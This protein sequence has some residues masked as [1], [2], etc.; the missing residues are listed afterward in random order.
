MI[1]AVLIDTWEFMF[2]YALRLDAGWVIFSL[3]VGY[4]V[5]RLARW[6]YT[7]DIRTRKAE[8]VRRLRYERGEAEQAGLR[9]LSRFVANAPGYFYTL[10][11][12]PD[13]SI[14]MPFASP[15]I[16]DIYGLR[17]EDVVEDISRMVAV[18]HPDDVAPIFAAMA[19]S[20][21]VGSPY[22]IEFRV[23]HP[24]KGELWVEARS[25]PQREPDGSVLWHGLMLDITERKRTKQALVASKQELL[26]LAD[27]SPDMIV[28]YDQDCRRTY[29]NLA[30][31]A[32]SG[33]TLE[34]ALGKSPLEL[35]GVSTT[36]AATFQ[37]MLEGVLAT[38]E[39]AKIELLGRQR[40]GTDFCYL[41][42][43]VPKYD[44][45]GNIVSVLTSARDITEIDHYRKQIHHQAFSDALT[46][47]PNR[48]LLFDR[49]RQV[50][51]DAAYHGHQF[52]LMM[53]DL[54]NFKEIND[55][56]GHGVG[57]AL[58]C[59][60][61]NRLLASVRSYDTVARL[62]GDEFLVLLPNMRR[63]DDLAT[64]AGKIL[65]ELA[66]P[67]V[68][69]GQELFVTCSIGIALYPGDSTEIEALYKYADSAMYHAKKMGRNNFQFYEP[70][71]TVRSQERME[72][73]TALRKAQK[74][75]ELVLYYQ[76]QIELQTGR[77]VSAEALLR[78]QRPGHG[79]MAPDRFIPT[80]EASGLI[81]GIGE[82]VLLS[83]CQDA[84]CWNRERATPVRVAVNLSTRQFIRN[85][86]VGSVRRVLAETGCNPAWLELEITE[87]LLMED[88]NEVATML[89][90]L[91]GMGLSI[92]IDDFGT[93]YSALSYL[94]RFPVSQIKIDRSFV[95]EIPAQKNKCELV[96]AMLSIASALHL[97]SVAEG[98]E[99]IE[100]A[101]YLMAH[102]CRLAQGY[103]FGKPMPLAEFEAVLA[104]ADA[105]SSD[106]A[107]VAAVSADD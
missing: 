27:N 31:T 16:K 36:S 67:F 53:L 73:E 24:G 99:T 70:E 63:G 88:N 105:S 64:I 81:L 96:K 106:E 26:T 46:G 87:S 65:H 97:E 13:G 91:H 69:D 58:L 52:G 89:A 107:M 90:A 42:Q 74:K 83:A 43:A 10:L 17:P 12:R 18:L 45:A 32:A 3:M 50:I 49:I 95:N 98:V 75:G 104:R 48:A 2:W 19:E 76:P 9:R 101:E 85:D 20:A 55:T 22:A 34:E 100:Q 40:D 93:G 94:N 47:L 25:V 66:E 1:F 41:L 68:L 7:R 80:A 11:Q 38:G 30:Y 72:T 8:E 86:L 6:T 78:W 14:A 61:A 33:L 56:M 44:G 92:S 5:H 35:W 37:A 82:W 28:R 21:R 54:D 51:A 15:G 29:V 103:L 62:G 39:A 57:D 23:N 71:F 77:L 4:F 79:M 59:T 60:A 84:V 102:G